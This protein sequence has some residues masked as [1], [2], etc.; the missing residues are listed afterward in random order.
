MFIWCHKLHSY[1]LSANLPTLKKT[2]VNG[3][4]GDEETLQPLLQADNSIY[5]QSKND[6]V[7]ARPTHLSDSNPILSAPSL[8]NGTNPIYMSNNNGSPLH[9][10]SPKA[11]YVNQDVV[12]VV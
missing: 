10:E 1:L 6:D 8:P 12:Q 3:A 2:K 9:K 7:R 11:D 4:D 5:L